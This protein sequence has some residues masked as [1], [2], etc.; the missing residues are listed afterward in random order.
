MPINP[1]GSAYAE[2]RASLDLMAQFITMQAQTM[3][4]QV[5]QQNVERENP[6]VR[7]MADRLR[8]FTRMNP[9]VFTRSKTSDDPQEF[10]DEVDNIL[11][12]MVAIDTKNVEMASYPL[13][14]VAQTW[15]KMW[16]DSRDLGGVPVIWELFKIA[17]LKRFFPREMREENIEEYINLKQGSMTVSEYS[18]MFVKLSRYATSLLSYNRDEMCRFLTRIDEDLE[19]ECTAAVLHDRMDL[20]THMVHFQHM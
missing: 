11:V 1:A 17:F 18:L 12:A 7:S 4:A 6:L 10:V 15:C 8:D 13:M 9:P 5:N 14:D 3:T 2:V 16:K 20:S 19:E